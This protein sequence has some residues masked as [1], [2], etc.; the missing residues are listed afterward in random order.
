MKWQ[1]VWVSVPDLDLIFKYRAGTSSTQSIG[2]GYPV[3]TLAARLPVMKT[4]N[5]FLLHSHLHHRYDSSS[6]ALL[7][8]LRFL[9]LSSPGTR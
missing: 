6:A 3:V 9:L 7:L 5:H 8:V 1:G 4:N 2:W